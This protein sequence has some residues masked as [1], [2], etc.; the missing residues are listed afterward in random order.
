MEIR[1]H[2]GN[3]DGNDSAI[4]FQFDN[5]GTIDKQVKTV[6][7]DNTV[8]VP[9]LDDLLSIDLETIVCQLSK[10]CADIDAFDKA[11]TECGVDKPGGFQDAVD[12]TIVGL[13]AIGN[14]NWTATISQTDVLFRVLL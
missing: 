14:S 8:A 11:G 1:L 6:R 2:L 13:H 10:E 3:V 12:K 4:R 9:H 7:T 5:R